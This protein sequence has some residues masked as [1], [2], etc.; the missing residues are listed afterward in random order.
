[1]FNNFFFSLSQCVYYQCT[2]FSKSRVFNNVICFVYIYV[3]IFIY[4]FF[5]LHS[6]I[7]DVV[8]DGNFSRFCFFFLSFFRRLLISWLTIMSLVRSTQRCR[9]RF[10]FRLEFRGILY[11]Q[12]FDTFFCVSV[13]LHRS[14]FDKA[15]QIQTK[16]SI[17][18]K[19]TNHA[20]IDVYSRNK[21][22]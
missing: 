16:E 15:H 12:L 19:W 5:F 18:I 10:R 9:F 17:K 4:F 21:S 7:A 6:C 1:M 8:V 11:C 22:A 20:R 3:C 14:R 2:S 13:F